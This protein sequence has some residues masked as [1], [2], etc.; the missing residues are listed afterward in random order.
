MEQR[1]ATAREVKTH[2]N[3][4][5][6]GMEEMLDLHEKWDAEHAEEDGEEEEEVLISG[7]VSDEEI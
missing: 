1:P 3:S 7:Q 2:V 5:Y 4:P 6:D